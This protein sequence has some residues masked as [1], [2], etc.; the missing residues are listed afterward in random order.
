MY[1]AKNAGRNTIRFF[2]PQMQTALESRNQLE[3]ELHEALLGNQFELHYQPQVDIKGKIIGAEALIRWRH[4]ERGLISPGT[5]IPMA[6]ESGL[7]VDIGEWVIAEACRQLARWQTRKEFQSLVLA[8]NV[9]AKQMGLPD[10]PERV[11]YRLQQEK[12]HSQK[13][14]LEITESLLLGDIEQTIFRMKILKGLGVSF[15]LDDFGT[16]YSSLQYLKRLPL[17][18]IKIDQSF[19]REICQDENDQAIVSTIIAMASHLGL[20]V[21]AEG[22]EDTAQRE[23]LLRRGCHFFQ[24]YLYGRPL[25]IVEFEALFDQPLNPGS[26]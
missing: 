9:S 20:S 14:K 18:Q 10:F 16:G 21:I 5:F 22:V 19:V 23:A 4:P 2:D 6:E 15:S 3:N 13:L 12:I 24:G 26:I 17:D 1:E 25:P 8:V 11:H 7:I